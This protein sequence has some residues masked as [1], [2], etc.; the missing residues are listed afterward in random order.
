MGEYAVQTNEFSCIHMTQILIGRGARGK[1]GTR[2]DGRTAGLAA[3]V[4]DR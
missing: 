1:A 3:P 2:R 4:G